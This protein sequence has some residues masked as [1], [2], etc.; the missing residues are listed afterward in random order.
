MLREAEI[1]HF[2]QSSMFGKDLNRFFSTTDFLKKQSNE[3]G[4]I[5]IDN[6][7]ISYYI[8]SRFNIF[9]YLVFTDINTNAEDFEIIEKLVMYVKNNLNVD[10]I[11]HPHANF[12]TTAKPI[13]SIA[14]PFATIVKNIQLNDNDLLMSI[15]EKHRN[16]IRSAIKKGVVVSRVLQAEKEHFLFFQEEQKKIGRKFMN[17][18]SFQNLL[19][20][21][22]VLLFKATNNNLI[23]AE[24][25]IAHDKQT[26]YYLYGSYKSGTING[27]MNL[28]LFEIMKYLRDSEVEQIDFLGVRINPAEGSKL[29]GIRK[30]K[31]RF[32]GNEIKGFLWKYPF[33]L[34]KYHL[35]QF[36][37]KTFQL[38]KIGRWQGDNIDQELEK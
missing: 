11:H 25:I 27:C 8:K 20:S 3:Y 15:H 38:V 30:F 21:K 10:F 17:Y 6:L 18:M 2:N 23:I 28:L 19:S 37:F 4:W 31:L 35:F 29:E 32:N 34:P 16:V 26:A 14:M 7:I 36:I 9:R 13:N 22:Q 24:A 12:I 1:Q 5:V 33:H